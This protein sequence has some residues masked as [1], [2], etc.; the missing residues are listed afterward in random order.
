MLQQ[1]TG[2]SERLDAQGYLDLQKA[3]W[4]LDDKITKHAEPSI[5]SVV[6]AAIH[7]PSF[8]EEAAKQKAKKKELSKLVNT[9]QPRYQ[10]LY[11]HYKN[12]FTKHNIQTNATVSMFLLFV[13]V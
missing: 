6:T 10:E 13:L 5:D 7:H 2:R 9:I 1:G 8:Q 12:K 4:A 3:V 11:T